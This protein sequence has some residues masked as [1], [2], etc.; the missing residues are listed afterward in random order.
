MAIR[1]A[2]AGGDFECVR[3]A[4]TD[5]DER[6]DEIARILQGDA[7]ERIDVYPMTAGTLM[8]FEGRRALHQVSPVR[9]ATARVVGLLGYDT[10]PGTTSSDLLKL[11]RYGRTEPLAD[12]GPTS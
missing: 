7:D 5:A 2:D 4:R 12:A 11:V 1:P 10:A 3:D 6:Y 9:G 8:V